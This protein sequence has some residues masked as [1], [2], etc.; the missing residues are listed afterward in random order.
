MKVTET[1]R[2]AQDNCVGCSR[3]SEKYF[4]DLPETEL[5]QFSSFKLTRSFRKGATLFTEG[6]PANGVH[7]LCS[8]RVKLSTYSAEGRSLIVR[9]VEPGEVL[10]L[11]ACIA[12][13]PHEGSAKVVADC[14]VS[15]IRRNE[16]LGLLKNSSVAALNA[17]RE[18]SH[19][20]HKA[21]AQICS[22]GLSV[23]ASDKLAK[24]LLDWC[25]KG[26]DSGGGVR[27]RMMY[28]HEEVAEMIGTSRETVTRS[29]KIF[30]TRGLIQVVGAY[31]IVLDKR[32][33]GDAIGRVYPAGGHGV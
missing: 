3:R 12:G 24:L 14:Q 6:Q 7:V 29:L 10:G 28:T 21:H 31:I 11:S 23:S 27:I 19:L 22:L 20:Y 13:V 30:K 17:I 9:V 18:L 4:C 1:I 5:R 25:G 2:R 15:F 8:G 33:L 26:E 16:L 32:R